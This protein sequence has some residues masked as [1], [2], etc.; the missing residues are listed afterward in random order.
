VSKK[1]MNSDEIRKEVLQSVNTELWPDVVDAL[2]A[3]DNQKIRDELTLKI[4]KFHLLGYKN[5][6]IGRMLKI[7][8]N[9]VRFRLD[10]LKVGD[11]D[12]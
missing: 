4:L 10:E 1:E 12:G 2:A 9:T 11:T 6:E 3:L 7:S 8:H 5:R